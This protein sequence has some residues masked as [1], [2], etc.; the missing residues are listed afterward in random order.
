MGLAVDSSDREEQEK[1][2]CR[3][4]V[5]TKSSY[6]KEKILAFIHYIGAHDYTMAFL[7]LIK[8]EKELQLDLEQGVR[9]LSDQP[10]QNLI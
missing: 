6:D 10:S 3:Y 4:C 5:T 2:H 1:L 8:Q 7:S 9:N